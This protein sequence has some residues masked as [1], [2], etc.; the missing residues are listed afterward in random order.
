MASDVIDDDDVAGAQG[1]DELLFDV[2]KEA[3]A[4]DRTVKDTRRGEPVTSKRRQEGDGAPLA[5]RSEADKAF[6][7][8][9]SAS[10]RRHVGLDP[11]LVDEH[12]TFRI[13]PNL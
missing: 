6:A 4:V 1:R 7:S 2:G 13:E 3:W 9:P 10:E 5:M 8:R 11:D 12:Q